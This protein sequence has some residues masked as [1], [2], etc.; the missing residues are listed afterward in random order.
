MSYSYTIT[1]GTYGAFNDLT[2]RTLGFQI[3][4]V[5]NVA[6]MGSGTLNIDL[7]NADGEL[8]PNGSGAYAGFDWASQLFIVTAA[9]PLETDFVLFHGFVVDVSLFDD[10]ITSRLSL[11][12]V[13]PYALVGRGWA[14]ESNVSP[15]TSIWKNLP[16]ALTDLLNVGTGAKLPTGGIPLPL[17]GADDSEALVNDVAT[18][19]GPYV[20]K[21]AANG[22]IESNISNGYLV[23]GI[24]SMYPTLVSFDS[25]GGTVTALYEANVIGNG[26]TN[27]VRYLGDRCE[28]AIT[29]SPT[30]GSSELALNAVT[31]GHNLDELVNQVEYVSG[32]EYFAS[33]Q[34]SLDLYGPRTVSFV[35]VPYV[36]VGSG[37]TPGNPGVDPQTF[38]DHW[39]NR[40]SEYRWTAVRVNTKASQNTSTNAERALLQLLDVRY[41]QWVPVEVTYTP[42]GGSQV[43]DVGIVRRRVISASPSDTVVMLDVYPAQDYASF[44][45]DSD[46]LGV[47]NQNRLG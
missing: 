34:A 23:P 10:G 2:S 29:E 11:T 27:D 36:R 6:Q 35:D 40:F 46:L 44:T 31:T 15:S 12:V 33:N 17:V 41:G 9:R 38:A 5:C 22:Y 7:D 4:Q 30:P 39:A 20:T 24:S 26:L 14:E 3:E 42:T 32:L 47:L 16:D 1:V 8:T 13:D 45:L 18:V 28:Y 19:V 43:T 37:T 21:D 25:S